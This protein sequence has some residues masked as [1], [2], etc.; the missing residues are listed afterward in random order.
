MFKSML[1][2]KKAVT[3]TLSLL[4]LVLMVGVYI[5]NVSDLYFSDGIPV[6]IR[7]E[8]FYNG[9]FDVFSYVFSKHGNSV[10]AS[11]YL[12]AW[13]NDVF[14]NG[15]MGFLKWCSFLSIVGLALM[16]NWI[17]YRKTLSV[18]E[19]L[20]V[21]IIADI[22]IAGTYNCELYLPFQNCLTLTRFCCVLLLWKMAGCLS[23]EKKK[24]WVLWLVLSSFA[25]LLHGVG[26]MFVLGIF[27]VHIATKQSLKKCIG[28]LLPFGIYAWVQWNPTGNYGETVA[29]LHRLLPCF[30]ELLLS[31]LSFYGGF[32]HILFGWSKDVCVGIGAL[33]FTATFITLLYFLI[34][35][36]AKIKW[37]PQIPLK[38]RKAVFAM[39]LLGIS[40]LCSIGSAVYVVSRKDF[41][42]YD[43]VGTILGTGRYLCYG[44][45]PYV[46]LLYLSTGPLK[47]QI[48]RRTLFLMYL[49][50]TLVL[51]HKND[52]VTER[53][54]TAFN[55]MLDREAI[56]LLSG[57][58]LDSGE[59]KKGYSNWAYEPFYALYIPKTY[60][61]LQE[62][63]RY[64]W[65]NQPVLG[66]KILNPT[67]RDMIQATDVS[68]SETSDPQYLFVQFSLP[69]SIG[70][71]YI[72][73]AN[74]KYAVVGFAHEVPHRYF[75]SG[76]RKLYF[77]RMY[78]YEGYVKKPEENVYFAVT[79]ENISYR[80]ALQISR[81]KD[82]P[83]SVNFADQT[84]PFEVSG[85]S[86]A[87]KWG[88]WTDGDTVRFRFNFSQDKPIK[89]S[90]KGVHA[91][92][93]P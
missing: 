33:S 56:A 84:L 24:H 12:L 39:G 51:I 40:F 7:L 18:S 73:L 64:I 1:Q 93:D 3:L 19:N 44:V 58:N 92:V 52:K 63:N 30:G 32:C 87:E 20:I 68:L 75:S 82:V 9:Q 6:L 13:I 21:F 60:Q 48:L 90:F 14:F 2:N 45:T 53:I 89:L 28:A 85:L 27:Y 74:E 65:H 77:R 37:L 70:K 38:N 31:I 91:R 76:K 4:F 72:P 46:I 17:M 22:I 62:S 83:L 86:Y 57:V 35:P 16:A 41:P 61:R 11:I 59:I 25:A 55:S 29:S 80:P 47:R 15:T 23:E 42:S 43:A 34:V 54:G 26:M 66:A 81:E 67:I 8:R 5:D 50:L 69:T 79:G 10:H 78:T 71:R 49:F 36:Y 88:R